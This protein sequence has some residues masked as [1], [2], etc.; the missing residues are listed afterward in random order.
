[1]VNANINSE[2]LLRVRGKANAA[3]RKLGDQVKNSECAAFC[4]ALGQ[5]VRVRILKLIIKEHCMFG[6]LARQIPLAQSTISQHLKILREA[7]LIYS[8]CVGQNTCYCVR[9]KTVEKF[10]RLIDNL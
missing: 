7:G 1:M 4:N 8:K 5:P 10:K 9:E 6:D 3:G 2:I